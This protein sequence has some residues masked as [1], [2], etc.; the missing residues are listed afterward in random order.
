MATGTWGSRCGLRSGK[1]GGSKEA[2]WVI[3]SA[4]THAGSRF[5]M[6]HL[7]KDTSLDCELLKSRH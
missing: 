2:G 4:H 5:R 6:W 7:G 1:A 3:S